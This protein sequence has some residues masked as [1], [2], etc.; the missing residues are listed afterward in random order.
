VGSAAEKN[1]AYWETHVYSVNSVDASNLKVER[2][3][4]DQDLRKDKFAEKSEE[5]IEDAVKDALFYDP[6]DHSDYI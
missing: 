4:R 1:E 5:Q 6:S 2:W 3:A